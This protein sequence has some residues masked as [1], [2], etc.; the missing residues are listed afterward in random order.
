MP[1]EMFDYC[2]NKMFHL[3]AYYIPSVIFLSMKQLAFI[4]PGASE[5]TNRNL[6]PT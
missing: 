4:S 6:L 3:C 5:G 1:D 2:I